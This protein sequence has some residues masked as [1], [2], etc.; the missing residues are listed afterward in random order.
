MDEAK[1]YLDKAAECLAQAANAPDDA[2]AAFIAIAEQYARLAEYA[3]KERETWRPERADYIQHD[4]E[5]GGP[6]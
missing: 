5:A 2:K 3:S 6:N 4:E 1:Q